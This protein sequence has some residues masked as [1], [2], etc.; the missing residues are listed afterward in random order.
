MT[1]AASSFLPG[2]SLDS[3]WLLPNFSNVLLAGSM[4]QSATN[5][6][7]A[8]FEQFVRAH[9]GLV[10]SICVRVLHSR[11][12]ATDAAQEIFLKLYQHQEQL[13]ASRSPAPFVARVARN[14]CIDL[15]R[16]RGT[17]VVTEA[18]ED[19]EWENVADGSKDA[20][21]QLQV[22]QNNDE[23]GA[24]LTHLPDHYQHVL[25]L[26]YQQGFTYQEIAESLKIPVGTVMTWLHRAKAQLKKKLEKIHAT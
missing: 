14:H 3:S 4:T 19:R 8:V 6:E 20:E 13:D 22:A 17:R 21:M 23:V 18:N 1:I 15:L 12:D 7:H 2:G 11:E 25:H 10:H 9:Q 24:V 26:Y 16:K 5:L